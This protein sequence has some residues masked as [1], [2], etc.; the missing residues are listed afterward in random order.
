MVDHEKRSAN[1]GRKLRNLL[2]R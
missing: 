2:L 1:C